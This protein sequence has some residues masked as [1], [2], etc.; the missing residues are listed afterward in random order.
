[1]I[2]NITKNFNWHTYKYFNQNISKLSEQQA[3][4]YIG[5]NNNNQ[6]I[7]NFFKSSPL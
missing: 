1:M 6:D 5:I 2:D 4:K 7:I 3:A